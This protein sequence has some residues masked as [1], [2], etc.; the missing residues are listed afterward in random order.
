MRTK[1]ESIQSLQ[2][3]ACLPAFAE[4]LLTQKLT[5]YVNEQL[6]LSRELDLPLLQHLSS[7]SEE[8]LYGMAKASIIEFLNYLAQNRAQEQI[9]ASI[10]NWQDNNLPMVDKDDII[11]EDISLTNYIRKRSF[12]HFLPAYS[13][14]TGHMIS[15][16]QEIDLFLLQSER[17]LTRTY[18][19]LLKNR[20]DEHSHFIEKIT[21]TSPGV[22][23]VYDVINHREIYTNK[24]V[25]DTLGYQQ[26][27]F[28]NMGSNFVQEVIHPDDIEVIRKH[29]QAFADIRDGE[30]RSVKYRVKNKSGEYRWMRTYET[31]FKRNEQ[32]Q[33]N[34]KIGIAIDVH[35]QKITA[36]QLRKS[37]EALLEAQEIAQLGSFTWDLESDTST[38]SPQ[39]D[40]ILEI[41][42]NDFKDFLNKVHPDDQQKVTDA[43]KRMVQSGHFECEFRYLGKEV[44]KTIWTKGLISFKDS[45]PSVMTGTVMDITERSAILSSLRKNEQLYRQA[46]A[47]THIGNYKWDLK[48][49]DL[50]WSDE[51]FRIYGLNPQSDQITYS[52]AESYIHPDDKELVQANIQEALN[53]QSTFDF[54]FRIIAQNSL[55]KILHARGSIELD[56]SGAPFA[57]IGTVQDETEKQTLIR[58][59]KHNEFLYKQAEELANMGNWNWDLKTNKVEWTDQLYRIYGL[60]PQSEEISIERFLSFVHPED[61]EK[62]VSGLNITNERHLDQVFR[63]IS[64]DGRTKTLR[65]IAQVHT[66]DQGQPI[67][68]IG[69]ERDI[70]EKQNLI[71][72]L[73]NSERLYKQAQ[74]L[75]HIG[76]WV[77]DLRTKE[78]IWSDEMYQ[79]YEIEKGQEISFDDWTAFITPQ[80]REEVLSFMEE[81]INEKKPYDKIHRVILRDGTMKNLHRK[82]ELVFNEVGQPIRMIGTT[83]DVTE[84]QR[85]QQELKDNQTFIKKIADAT[86]SIIASYNINTGKYVFISEGIYKLLGYHASE[87]LAKGVEFFQNIIH[88]DDLGPLLEKNNTAIAHANS[89]VAP[90]D[91]VVEFNYRMRHQNGQYRWFHTYGTIFDRN[92]LGLVEHVL[93]ISLDITDQVNATRKIEEQEHFIQHIADASPTILYVFDVPSNSIAYTNREVYFVLGYT[94][95]DMVEMGPEVVTNLYHPEDF[96][97]LPERRESTK[98]FQHRDSMMQYE[99]RI[100][101]IDGEYKWMLVR[102]IIFKTDEEG[103]VLQLLGAALDISKRKDMERT[104]LQN[105]FQLQQSNASLEEFAYVAS[106]DL[107]EP[108]RKISTFGDRLIATQSDRLSDDGKIYLNKII[109]ASQRMQTMISDL[110]TVSMI[111]GDRSYERYSLQSILQDVL[112]TL[113]YKTEQKNALIQADTLPE[114]NIIPSQFRQLFQNLLSNSLKFVRDGVQP[115]ITIRHQFISSDDVAGYQLPKAEQYLKLVFQDNGIGFEE[116]YAGKIF[117]IFQRLHGRSEYEGTGIG[118]AI[119]KKIVE[120]HGGVIFASGIPNQGATFTIIL[121]A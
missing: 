40:K 42:N 5:E 88:P 65:S 34:Q 81:C 67:Y 103:K 10:Q 94:P 75:A 97:L 101:T 61:K 115:V 108:L 41:K 82:G 68:V 12:L 121:P 2:A 39:T 89:G 25:N 19:S 60:E 51:L 30:I 44:E 111:T 109:D 56:N 105:A 1:T 80:E 26:D 48:T 53:S 64:Q 46:E 106:H 110:L 22:I 100:K 102:E 74:A 63:I 33:V 118:L 76:N 107:K 113:E 35:Q 93:N 15:L 92:E 18:I 29:E 112:Q 21:D 50:K 32:G 84:Q 99:C 90:N 54:Y 38:T 17:A 66:D 4:Y 96:E 13:Q 58:Q 11:A 47:L 36:D 8:E 49:N 31:V 77:L 9:N 16:I 3:L 87:V 91:M 72:K 28:I 114:A 62:V 24:I 43:L 85:I 14:D 52:I 116:E 23:Y 37:E 73:Q 70:T 86:P 57:I 117:A 71:D 20:I 119:C 95:E 6:R 79:I 104:I 78:Y 69:T 59:L 27:E 98:R 83:Q 45:K 55:Q 120:H 7:L